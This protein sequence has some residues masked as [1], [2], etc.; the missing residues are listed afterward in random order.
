MVKI[1]KDFGEKSRIIMDIV[2]TGKTYFE[3]NPEFAIAELSLVSNL[4][5]LLYYMGLL[6]YG[7]DENGYPAFV[8]P[9][10]TVR[11]QYCRYLAKCYSES[12]GW[13]TD[14]VLLDSY[15]ERLSFYGDCKPMISYIASVMCENSSVRDFDSQGEFFVKGF[16]LSHFCKSSGYIAYTELETD[17]GYTDLFL[18]PLGYKRH[19]YMIE[20]KYCKKIPQMTP[21]PNSKPTPNHRCSVT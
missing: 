3:L 4:K 17:H 12:L 7:L 18:E 15:W 10:E 16:F 1:E 21:S 20:L 6:S 14:S 5:S 9:N 11:Q 2:N 19:A 8:V 13:R